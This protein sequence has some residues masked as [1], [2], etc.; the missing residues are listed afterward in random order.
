MPATEIDWC[1]AECNGLTDLFFSEYLP[2]KR[3]AQKICFDC[4]IM[5]ACH[6]YAM[7]ARITHG[8]YGGIV[9]SQRVLMY[10]ALD[11]LRERDGLCPTTA[12]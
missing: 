9:A 3:K 7:D 2:D 10:R 1:L 8:I 6:Q 11:H 5:D 12:A 4:P